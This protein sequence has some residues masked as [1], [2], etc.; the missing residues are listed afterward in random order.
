[1]LGLDFGAVL[2][3]GFVLDFV[4]DFGADFGVFGFGVLVVFVLLE[5][6]FCTIWL[7]VRGGFFAGFCKL[8]C[9]KVSF[10]KSLFCKLGFCELECC[11]SVEVFFRFDEFILSP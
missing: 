4:R 3:V 9:C 1:M 2:G 8:F 5:R 6:R 10:C 11:E 7:G